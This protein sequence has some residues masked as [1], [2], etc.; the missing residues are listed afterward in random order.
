MDNVLGVICVFALLGIGETTAAPRLPRP[1]T[2]AHE[3]PSPTTF[4]RSISWRV[5]KPTPIVCSDLQVT[6]LT[7]PPASELD[8]RRGSDAFR[9]AVQNAR[10]VQLRELEKMNRGEKDLRVI[11]AFPFAGL[12]NKMMHTIS[13][14]LLSLL[15]N[16]ALFINNSGDFF[17][18][19]FDFEDWRATWSH[20]P[21]LYR[22]S[23][24]KEKLLYDEYLYP[25]SKSSLGAYWANDPPHAYVGPR[26]VL[27]CSNVPDIFPQPI[28]AAAGNQYTLPFLLM[29]RQLQDRMQKLGMLEGTG[30]HMD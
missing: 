14:L 8:K 7:L 18:G 20:L 1:A 27:A 29:N 4:R 21:D 9:R 15:T 2:L 26:E 6:N 12:G 23:K 22:T 19:T 17:Q 24:F 3:A 30:G 28:L 5:A 16:R 13:L 11:L 10:L 25:S